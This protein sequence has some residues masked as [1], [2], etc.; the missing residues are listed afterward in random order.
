[1]TYAQT[2]PPPDVEAHVTTVLEGVGAVKVWAYDSAPESHA[3]L[4]R[5]ALQVDVRASSK[6]AARDRAYEARSRLLALA[7]YGWQDGRVAG[8]EVITGPAWLP[9]EDG[10]PRY[11]MRV[12]VKYGRN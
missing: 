11:V 1:M 12:A 10:A 4:E 7:E 2:D 3:V 8:V 5:T 6:Q 9:D